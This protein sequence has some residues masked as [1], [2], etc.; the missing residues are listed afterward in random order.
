L[1]V[2]LAQ[3]P[4]KQAASI[5]AEITGQKKNRLYEAALKLGSDN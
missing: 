2:L 3:L 5:T 4:V 1:S